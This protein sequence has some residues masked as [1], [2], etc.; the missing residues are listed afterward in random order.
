MFE[1][2]RALFAFYILIQTV[3]LALR[4]P[5]IKG[6]QIGHAH[7][8][9]FGAFIF[10]LLD[11]VPLNLAGQ[12]VK[13]LSFPVITIA[14]LMILKLCIDEVGLFNW[15]SQQ[16]A[17]RSKGCGKKLFF[18]IFLISSITGAFFS[19]D[20]AVLIFTPVV[21]S[22]VE[23][24]Q[25][26]D[27]GMK[28]KIPYYF[29]VLCIT[30][31]VGIFVISNPINI[32]V[33]ELFSIPF[34]QYTKWMAGPAII[35]IV[36]SYLCLRFYFRKGIPTSFRPI[37]EEDLL[38][39][40]KKMGISVAILISTL[41]LLFLEPLTGI[42]SWLVVVISA[43]IFLLFRP[44]FTT[45]RYIKVLTGVHW[46]IIIFIL[47]IYI[48]AVGIR[49]VGLTQYLAQ[50]IMQISGGVTPLLMVSTSF[51]SGF[52]SAIMNNHPT[53]D[54]MVMTIRDMNLDKVTT[55]F[56]AFSSLI[57]GDLGPKML[58]TG[59]LAALLWFQ[60]L[61]QKGV[62]VSYGL[63]IKIGVPITL[64]AIL[65]SIAFLTLEYAIFLNL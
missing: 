21:F 4:R 25:H 12:S 48:V 18:T 43:G 15:L 56:L 35:S 60:L 52:L 8:A 20:A 24:I 27:W 1:G 39:F 10:I 65:F 11:I 9:T 38:P 6:W 28:N 49:N 42:T 57:G 54:T 40:T 16:M 31:V 62:E 23:Q 45:N 44:Y 41:V 36:I 30:N 34:L 26:E 59:S 53:A 2:L 46:D 14:S 58:P 55:Q 19:N 7:A 64:V 13:M 32:I 47:G 37:K 29:S 51:V 3:F 50:W 17:L 33:S 5:T 61:R 22:L 63:Y